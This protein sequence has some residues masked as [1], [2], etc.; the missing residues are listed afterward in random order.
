MGFEDAD[1][2]KGIK[3]LVEQI[4]NGESKVEI[5][6]TRAVNKNGNVTANKVLNEVFEDTNANWRGLG[7]IKKSGLKFR[8][9]YAAFDAGKKFKVKVPDSSLPKGCVCGEVLQGI[10]SPA[11]CK[12]FG[13]KCTPMTPVGPCMVS[14]EGTC[15]AYYKYGE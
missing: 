11:D 12:L 4:K 14:S 2:V 6:Y 3:R 5:E 7:E 9:E 15:A 8:K 1:I 10:K 13:K